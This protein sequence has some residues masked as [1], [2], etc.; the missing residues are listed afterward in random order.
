MHSDGK[1]WAMAIWI[2]HNTHMSVKMAPMSKIWPKLLDKDPVSFHTTLLGPA[3][4]HLPFPISLILKRR[5]SVSLR[6]DWRFLPAVKCPERYQDF[7]HWPPWKTALLWHPERSISNH[8]ADIMSSGCI[9]WW[10]DTSLFNV[11]SNLTKTWDNGS[12]GIPSSDM[13]SRRPV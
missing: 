1:W 8:P 7:L 6:E 5:R 12:P 4:A 10:T 2:F 11:L 9:T 3:P 13:Q